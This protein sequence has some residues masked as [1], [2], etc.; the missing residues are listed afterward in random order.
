MTTEGDMRSATS[1]GG[2][3]RGFGLPVAMIWIDITA[4]DP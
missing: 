2:A 1:E 4:A 3:D